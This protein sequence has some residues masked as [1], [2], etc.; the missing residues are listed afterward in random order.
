MLAL[1]PPPCRESSDA[2]AAPA[3]RPWF[4]PVV[5]QH[6]VT[7]HRVK[8]L[9]GHGERRRAGAP[10]QSSESGGRGKRRPSTKADAPS[11]LVGARGDVGPHS[12]QDAACDWW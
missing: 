6:D 5:E 12:S 3:A 9:A 1:L 7:Y 10:H 4:Y 2:A 8:P 11:E